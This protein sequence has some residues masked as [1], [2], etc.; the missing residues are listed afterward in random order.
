GNVLT[1]PIGTFASGSFVSGTVTLLAT[2]AGVVTNTATISAIEPDIV[3]ANNSSS[4][5]ITVTVP[6]AAVRFF[7][8]RATNG[9]NLLE[10]QNPGG[11]MARIVIQR[12]ATAADCLFETDPAAPTPIHVE[13]SPT[14]NAYD[15]FVDNAV[16]NNTTY[17]Y[18][19][20]V[21]QGSAVFSP[22]H[23]DPGR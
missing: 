14:P 4:A 13:L 23:F 1:C 7:T 15:T 17:C 12:T 18:S 5:T 9:E 3:P 21:D 22:G 6:G 20:F 19:I 16:T 10:W 8:V 2:G 11:P